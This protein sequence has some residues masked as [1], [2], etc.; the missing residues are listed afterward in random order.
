MTYGLFSGLAALISGRMVK[1][2]PE[3]A[4]IYTGI[5]INLAWILF[6]L[7][8]TK[9]PNFFVIFGFAISWGLSDGIWN[10]MGPG[11][12]P[13]VGDSFENGHGVPYCYFSQLWYTHVELTV[14]SNS[15]VEFAVYELRSFSPGLRVFKLQCIYD[16]LPVYGLQ[17]FILSSGISMLG[18]S[19]TPDAHSDYF[20][21]VCFLC[22]SLT[23]VC[24]NFRS[25]VGNKNGICIDRV[26]P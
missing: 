6:L 8:W 26:F 9:S 22:D 16:S 13:R 14:I 21:P 10:T 5:S 7:F 19:F 11:E 2:I 18:T 25:F 17:Y 1:Y 24:E 15:C 4:L 23:L 12:C 3:Y 20:C